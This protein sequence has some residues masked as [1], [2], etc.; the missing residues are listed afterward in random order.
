MGDIVSASKLARAG[1]CGFSF[2]PDVAV[3][4]TPESDAAAEGT[5][6][7]AV[8]ERC[9]KEGQVYEGAPD[10]ALKWW[11][12]MESLMP[13]SPMF[14]KAFSYDP[15]TGAVSIEWKYDRKAIASEGRIGCKLDLAGF[16]NER[17]YVYDYK[18]GRYVCPPEEADQLLIAALCMMEYT[19]TSVASIG[20]VYVGEH[21]GIKA[22]T[23]EVSYYEVLQQAAKWKAALRSVRGS[24]PHAGEHCHKTYCPLAGPCPATKREIMKVVETDA[25]PV[26]TADNVEEFYDL[27]KLV[28]KSMANWENIIRQLC[29]DSG[30]ELAL[31]SGKRLVRTKVTRKA[32]DQ[33]EA[34]RL[35]AE[36][37]HPEPKT[38]SSYFR[39]EVKK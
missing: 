22:D 31:P 33:A 3:P 19:G 23:T 8:M 34:K 27:K 6:R 20:F 36:A 18:T 13:P 12:E 16:D 37:G 29:D 28:K 2:R 30:G 15:E 21:G 5:E 1:A 26:L 4:N 38:E 11:T 7:H 14:E 24:G 25:T 39:Y 10:W 17:C 32:F 35:L 9:G